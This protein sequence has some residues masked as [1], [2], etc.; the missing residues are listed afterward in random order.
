LQNLSDEKFKNL[1]RGLT[2]DVGP[3][4]IQGP[5]GDTGIQGPK[6]DTGIQ[7]PIGIQGPKG[8][9]GIQ[10]PKGDTGIQGPK[11]DTGIAGINNFAEYLIKIK[12]GSTLSETITSLSEKVAGAYVLKFAV[13]TQRIND[14]QI[15][16]L[17]N[18]LTFNVIGQNISELWLTTFCG[19]SNSDPLSNMSNGNTINL[20]ANDINELITSGIIYFLTVRFN[21]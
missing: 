1:F 8:D 17:Q 10:G 4:G 9:T 7:G 11:G 3:I 14:I 5:K 2:G 6:G 16:K 20:T 21:N 13:G 19:T 15:S 18:T 12:A